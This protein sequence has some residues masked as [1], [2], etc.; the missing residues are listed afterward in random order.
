MSTNVLLEKEFTNALKDTREPNEIEIKNCN[1]IAESIQR[2]KTLLYC[3]GYYEYELGVFLLVKEDKI[4]KF[5]KAKLKDKF[6][7][8]KANEILHSLRVD[9]ALG[10]SE[11]LNASKL[12]N[13]K[14]G[15][16][17]LETLKLIP[18]SSDF[19]ST[20]QLPV[21]YDP[22]AKCGKW[23]E[24]L[25]EIFLDDIEKADILQEFFG[26]CLT[27]ETKYEK[28]LFTIGEGANG[29]STILHILQQILG[30]RNYSSVP[31]ELFNNPH[32]TANFYNRLANI[33]IETNAKSSVYDSLMKAVISG[34]TISADLKYQNVIQF[35]PFCKLIFALNSMPRV[36]D[37]TDAFYRR[38]IVLRFNRQFKEDEQNKNL[39]HELEVEMDGIFAWMV[40]GLRRLRQRG[41]FELST[42]IKQEVEEYRKE[43]NN[44]LTFVEEECNLES[45]AIISK[46]ELYNSYS[47]WCKKN[48]YKS[49]AKK[50]FGK[51]LAK[52]FQGKITDGR[53]G[54]G[55]IRIWMGVGA[56]GAII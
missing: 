48:G 5:I 41:Y 16:F 31:L 49:L 9:I 30:K 15:M 37:K 50:K 14:N 53:S 17:D 21:N 3:D 51:E 6:T 7:Q 11:D 20:I 25:K 40:E 54:S 55:D 13:L 28:A 44:V 22:N 43:N 12:L 36:D 52:H 29:K 35:N 39:K 46:Q 45:D 1:Q 33:S 42:G 23:L 26:L 10:C 19:K 38:I 18:H 2:D 24:S 32:Y 4:K 56:T 47:E 34:D 27:K 8:F